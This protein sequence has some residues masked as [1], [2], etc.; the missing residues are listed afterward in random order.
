MAAIGGECKDKN[1]QYDKWWEKLYFFPEIS[2]C[3]ESWSAVV[4]LAPDFT[5]LSLR[6]L[7]PLQNYQEMLDFYFILLSQTN[8]AYDFSSLL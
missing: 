2:G 3:F 6:I 8:K 1:L 5:V 7:T 4:K